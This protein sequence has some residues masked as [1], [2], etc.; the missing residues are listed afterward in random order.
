[1]SRKLGS[2]IAGIV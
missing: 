2:I 1:M